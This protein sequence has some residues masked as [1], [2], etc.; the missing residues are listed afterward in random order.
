ME[1]LEGRCTVTISNLLA[2][3]DH[4]YGGDSIYDDWNFDQA[5]EWAEKYMKKVFGFSKLHFSDVQEHPA[6]GK[7]FYDAWGVGKLHKVPGGTPFT[8]YEA[9]VTIWSR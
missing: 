6:T 7:K 8:P 2:G 5:K 9:L 3:G 1:K 4:D